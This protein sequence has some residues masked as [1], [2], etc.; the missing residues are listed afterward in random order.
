MHNKLNKTYLHVTNVKKVTSCE[1]KNIGL[2]QVEWKITDRL[3]ILKTG[4]CLFRN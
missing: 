4:N 3:K 1:N 2:K